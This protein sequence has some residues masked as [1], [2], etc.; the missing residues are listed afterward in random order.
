MWRDAEECYLMALVASLIVQIHKVRE[1]SE[2]WTLESG[3]RFC[4]GEVMWCVY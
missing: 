3:G 2:A 4:D 1:R